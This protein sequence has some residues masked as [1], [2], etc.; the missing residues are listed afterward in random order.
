ME[1]IPSRLGWSLG[2][3]VWH[4]SGGYY[5]YGIFWDGMPDINYHN[6]EAKQ[7]IFD[8]AT[9]WIDEV[10]IDGFRLDAVK[11]IYEDERQIEDLPATHQ[12]FKDFSSH[13]KGYNPNALTVGEAWTST[14][15][16][17]PYVLDERIDFC[18]EFDLAGSIL[19]A[20]NNASIVGLKD[21]IGEIISAYPYY[22]FGTFLTNHDQN[23]LAN[24][25]SESTDKMKVAAI[26]YLT[27]QGVPFLYY[28]EEIGMTGEKPD[29]NIRRPMA[30]ANT[31]YAGFSSALPWNAP[32]SNY[33]SNNVDVMA[34]DESSLL[35]HYIKLIQARTAIPA[36]QT[37]DY[38]VVSTSN[39]AVLAYIR[40][41]ENQKLLVIVNP[42]STNKSFNVDFSAHTAQNDQTPYD[43]LSESSLTNINSSGGQLNG[44]FL[45][46]YESMVLRFDQEVVL[47]SEGV[48][49][50]L[51]YPNPTSGVI[52]FNRKGDFQLLGIDGTIHLDGQLNGK[53]LDLSPLPSGIY[54]LRHIQNRQQKVYRINKH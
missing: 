2:Q 32:A 19:N 7:E 5:Y 1:T 48:A 38:E 16:V 29:E 3:N 53:T 40:R 22:Q 47:S 44:F 28:G 27:L 11:Y 24:V 54:I 46:P 37:G 33:P 43:L 15:K 26:I 42:T 50:V 25:L 9:F 18:F 8:A 4:Q 17:V 31:R 21:K 52:H 12:F 34:K 39:A 36:L 35:N 13:I 41:D 6:E 30:W 10:G 20:A 14:E 45:G 49:D 51:P 23:R